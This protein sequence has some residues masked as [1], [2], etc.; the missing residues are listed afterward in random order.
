ML[1]TILAFLEEIPGTFWAFIGGALGPLAAVFLTNHAHNRRLQTQLDHDR[2]L[3]NREREMSLRRDVYLEVAEAVQAGLIAVNRFP[4]LEISNEQ[5]TEAYVDKAPSIAKVHIIAKDETVSAVINFVGELNATFFRLFAARVP[6]VSQK[7][8]ID[9]L[10]AQVDIS[11]KEIFRT[12]ELMRQHNLD[13]LV[14]QRKWEVLQQNFELERVRSDKASQEAETLGMTLYLKQLQYMEE[15]AGETT[16]LGNFVTLMVLSAR[17]E[18]ELPIN[19]VEYR[20]VI[21]EASAKQQADLKEFIQH[22]QSIIVAETAAAGDVPPV[23][24][25]ESR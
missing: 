4:N 3:K 2:N 18:L 16:K 11:Q 6:L 1:T 13:G 21:G 10:K 24:G 15:C 23:P 20:R 5:V 17:L 7:H 9:A 22:L 12:L 25:A 14:D 8:K 19:E